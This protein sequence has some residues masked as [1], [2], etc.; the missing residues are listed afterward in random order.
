MHRA[1]GRCRL[2]PYAAVFFSLIVAR[3]FA[4]DAAAQDSCP[5]VPS[6]GGESI[7]AWI[8][9]KDNGC[10]LQPDFFAKKSTLLRLESLAIATGQCQ[11][12]VL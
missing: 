7:N 3:P 8:T 4:R 9:R 5:D 1:I 6:G 12:R 2:V 11:I 10:E